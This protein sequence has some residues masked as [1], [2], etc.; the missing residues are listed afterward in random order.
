MSSRFITDRQLPDKAVDVIDEAASKVM[1]EASKLSKE[2]VQIFKD[3]EVVRSELSSAEKEDYEESLDLKGRQKLLLDQA[4]EM[5]DLEKRYAAKIVDAQIVSEVVAL[6]TGIPV[7]KITQEES[8]KL[9]KMEEELSKKIIGQ[10]EAVNAVVRAVKR[11]KVGLKN[12]KRPT[13]SFLFLGPTGVGKSELA[14]QMALDLFGKEDAMIRIDMSEYME[15]HT[16]SRLIG[17]PPG[18]VGYDDGGQ[19]TEPVRQKPY[20]IVLFDEIEK[21]PQTF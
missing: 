4:G 17:S 5:S 3:L 21:H 9:L 10:Q 7:T 8:E 18:Y 16:V 14:K 13:G 6:W 1:L 20:S 19:L 11:S 12:P 15:K 2:S